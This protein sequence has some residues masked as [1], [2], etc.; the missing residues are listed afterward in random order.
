[1][2]VERA[3]TSR[4][5][6]AEADVAAATTTI[7]VESPDRPLTTARNYRRLL[8]QKQAAEKH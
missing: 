7:W 2:Q 4:N 8:R 1:M 5:G 3:Y 6:Q